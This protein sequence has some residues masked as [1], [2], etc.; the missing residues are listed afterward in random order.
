M[1]LG[2]VWQRY[3]ASFAETGTMGAPTP[4]GPTGGLV[5]PPYS[6][7]TRQTLE[8]R[9]AEDGG[10]RLIQGLRDVTCAFWDEF[11]YSIY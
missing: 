2:H 11:G 6:A 4:N 3:W 5:W 8:F 10:L 7:A 9:T 1:D